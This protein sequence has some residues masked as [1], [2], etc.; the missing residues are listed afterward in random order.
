MLAP[1]FTRFVAIDIS[2]E[3]VQ[4]AAKFN[5]AQENIQFIRGDL[6]FDVKG[7]VDVTEYTAISYTGE[8]R[9]T[10]WCRPCRPGSDDTIAISGK[11]AGPG[12]ERARG[13]RDRRSS[14]NSTSSTSSGPRDRAGVGGTWMKVQQVSDL[15]HHST[16]VRCCDRLEGK[17]E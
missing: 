4:A 7:A 2:G 14:L 1:H 17:I 5:C 12:S 16:Y 10:T 9:S 8:D 6:R 13:N 3:A 11:L 15:T